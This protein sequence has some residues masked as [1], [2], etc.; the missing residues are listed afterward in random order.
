MTLNFIVV[1]LHISIYNVISICEISYTC[2]KN[3]VNSNPH[4]PSICFSHF[5]QNKLELDPHAG[6]A[7]SQ[8]FFCIDGHFFIERFR[9]IEN[10]IDF[11]GIL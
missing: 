8:E 3:P 11:S 9:N 10:N 1:N 6:L 5:Y 7:E 2:G 4:N